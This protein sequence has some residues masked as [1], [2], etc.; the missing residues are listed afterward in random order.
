MQ[1]KL[2][3]ADD[4]SCASRASAGHRPIARTC[5]LARSCRTRPGHVAGGGS[6]S[7]PEHPLAT[8]PPLG[9]LKWNGFWAKKQR[10][11]SALDLLNRAETRLALLCK[12]AGCV[13][14]SELSSAEARSQRRRQR[15]AAL[16]QQEDLIL[17]ESAGKP[18]QAFLEEIEREDHDA[19]AAKLQQLRSQQQDV[20]KRLGELRETIGA[21]QTTLDALQ[22]R[23]P[24]AEAAER[25]ES[26]VAGLRDDVEQYACLK[27]ADLLL[28]RSLERYRER[29]RNPIVERASELFARL[30]AGSF[31][32]LR[33]DF[34]DDGKELLKGY[35]S[36]G[37]PGLGV[38][39]NELG[40]AGSTLSG[41]THCQSR[42][43]A[44]QARAD[45]TDP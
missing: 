1:K 10:Q 24:S 30:S 5:N 13:A 31:A 25:V 4:F 43:M 19:T 39:S 45:S 44:C 11:T 32:G 40:N 29:N 3:E 8:E 38:E 37:S 42:S 17:A 27:L 12:E 22:T 18:L 2:S 33:P 26:L 35:R 16:K 21:E 23:A 9:T 14:S 7:G 15:E 20:D 36:A 28:R 34:D 6:G 41:H